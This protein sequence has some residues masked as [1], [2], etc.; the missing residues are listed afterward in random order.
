MGNVEVFF[1]AEIY[2][3]SE[4]ESDCLKLIIIIVY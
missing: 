3:D 1:E 2:D 4:K